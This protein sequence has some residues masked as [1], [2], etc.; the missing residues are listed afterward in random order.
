MIK[1]I[2]RK[3]KKSLARRAAGAVVRGAKAAGRGARKYRGS[4]GAA[5]GAGAG[6]AVG[7]KMRKKSKRRK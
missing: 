6:Y 7:K 4:V 5:A 1:R 3:K 2:F